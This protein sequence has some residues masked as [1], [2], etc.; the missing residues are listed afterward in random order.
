MLLDPEVKKE[1]RAGER[2]LAIY[3]LRV[4]GYSWKDISNGFQMNRKQ[5]EHIYSRVHEW[6]HFYELKQED[7]MEFSRMFGKFCED[8]DVT[9]LI[10]LMAM[11]GIHNMTELNEIN[12]DRRV[13]NGVGERYI[14]VLKNVQTYLRNGAGYSR[15]IKATISAYAYELLRKECEQNKETSGKVITRALLFYC[16]IENEKEG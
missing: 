6:I 4:A 12:F 2:M 15:T 13:I 1:F 5:A 8:R 10:S 11:N 9:R 16:G 7:I 14:Q 3:N